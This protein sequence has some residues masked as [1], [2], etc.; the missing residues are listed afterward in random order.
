M[1][2]ATRSKIVGILLIIVSIILI[3]FS[4][5]SKIDTFWGLYISLSLLALALSF[6]GFR[7]NVF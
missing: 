4:L 7:I 1:R 5:S 3:L 2:P 6:L